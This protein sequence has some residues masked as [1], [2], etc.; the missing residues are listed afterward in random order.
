MLIT[1]TG[2]CRF[3]I[4]RGTAAA[5]GPIALS[6]PI[7]PPSPTISIPAAAR[8]RLIATSLLKVFRDFLTAN[9]LSADWDQVAAA[10]NESLVNTLVAAGALSAARQAGAA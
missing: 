7:L 10:S 6:S 9:D 1:L 3:S 5:R 2:V 8:R 4:A